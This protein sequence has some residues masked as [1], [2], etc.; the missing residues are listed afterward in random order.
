[1][2]GAFYKKVE[3]VLYTQRRPF[4]SDALNSDGIDR[5][6]YVFSGIT[7][8]GEGRIYGAEAAAQLQLD[9]WV[10]SLNVP[11]WMGG[12]GVSGNVTLNNS[13]VTKPAIGTVPARRVRLPGTSDLV[14]NLGGYYEKY[15][16]S[17]RLNYQFRSKW[18]DGV[19]DDLAGGGDTYWYDDD[20][21]DFS[22]RYAVNRNVEL[23][24]DGTNLLNNPGRRF[25]DP[26]SLLSA[27]G[28]RTP[29]I[30]DYTIEWERFGR[31]YTAGVRVNF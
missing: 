27:T 19:A 14:Y 9:P 24:V 11:E 13:K 16:L 12:F 22:A 3:D 26:G 1:M 7:N 20:E 30:E 23:Y 8:G 17:L 28:F 15:G 25:S 10:D 2:V 31:R 4:G 5:S 6:G 21:L 29:S 18:L